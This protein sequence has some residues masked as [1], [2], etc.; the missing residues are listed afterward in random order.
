[1]ALHVSIPYVRIRIFSFAEMPI[2]WNLM[3]VLVAAL[4]FVK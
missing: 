2:H 4:I 3:I 1:M